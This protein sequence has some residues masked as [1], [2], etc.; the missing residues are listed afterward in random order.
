MS[1][2]SLDWSDPVAVSRWLTGLQASFKDLDGVALD[3]LRPPRKRE[4]GPTL[5]A[6][7]YHA[8]RRQ[9]LHAIEHAT[10]PDPDP[11]DP[12]GQGD[13]GPVH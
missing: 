1:R 5:H 6:A 7:N 9:I 2:P 8:A 13:A 12:S 11:G 10:A 4:L 3:M